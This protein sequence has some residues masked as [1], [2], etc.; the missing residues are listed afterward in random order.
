MRFLR[1]QVLGDGGDVGMLA[2]Q[3]GNRGHSSSLANKSREETLARARASID[4][5]GMDDRKTFDS[6]CLD[7]NA[8]EGSIANRDV[9]SFSGGKEGRVEDG[10]LKMDAKHEVRRSEAF[11]ADTSTYDSADLEDGGN[12]EK[13]HRKDRH[14]PNP[15]S[16]DWNGI[17]HIAAREED[18]DE[19]VR[20]ENSR[21]KSDVRDRGGGRVRARGRA[22]DGAVDGERAS[23]QFTTGENAKLRKE[24]CKS[25]QNQNLEPGKG[26]DGFKD[27]SKKDTDTIHLE[28]DGGADEHHS[29]MVGITDIGF[30]IRKAACAAEEEAR[31]AFAPPE[32]VKAAGDAAAELVR[33][34]SMEALATTNDGEAVLAA[35]NAAVAMVVDAA[36][37]T[38]VSRCAPDAL[39]GDGSVGAEQASEMVG[40]EFMVDTDS[41]EGL[42]ERFCVQCLEKLGEYLEILGPVLQEK[43]VDVCLTL[44][45]RRCRE[46][47]TEKDMTMLSEILKLIC[48]LAAHRKFAALLV[49]RGGV[50]QLLAT[51]RVPQTFSG[52]SL[53]LFAFAS[54]QAVMERV[55]TLPSPI[56]QDVVALA[57]QLLECPQDSA[58]RNAVLFF[59]ASFVF[60]AVLDAFD[61]L[62]GPSKLLTLLRCTVALRSGGISASISGPTNTGSSRGA[63][64]EVLTS[65]GKQI[66][67]HTCVA[68]RQYFRAHLLLLV[69]SLRP[70][71]GRLA[72]RATNTGRAAYKP[73]DISNEAIETIIQQLQ[74]DRKLGPAF[75]RA[76]WL[77]LE[78]FMSSGGH[79]IFLE[80]TQVAPGERYLHEIAQHSLGVLQIVTLM[81]YTRRLVIGSTLSNDRSGMAVILD[82]ASGAGFGDPE[83][84]QPAL[85]V[86]VNLVCPPPSLSSRSGVTPNSSTV[87]QVV[88]AEVKDLPGRGEERPTDIP[89]STG[90]N[91]LQA[92]SGHQSAA[93]PACG[94][95][96]DSRISLGPGSGG[97]GLAAY[98]EQGYRYAREA[99][100]ANNGIKV[101][102]H[103]LYPRTV[104][105]P[106]ALDCIRALACRVLLGLA[107]DDAIAQILTKLQV[108]KLLSEL[109][110]DGIQIGRQASATGD[111]GRWQAELNRVAMDLIAI[112]TNAGRASTIASEAAAPTLRRIERAAIAAATPISYHPR[113]LLQLMHEHLSS[114]GLVDSAATLLKEAQL[115]PLPTSVSAVSVPVFSFSLDSNSQFHQWPS[116][117][118]SGGFPDGAWKQFHKDGENGSMTDVIQS[119]ARKKPSFS[120]MLSGGLKSSSLTPMR[121]TSCTEDNRLQLKDIQE[122]H[123]EAVTSRVNCGDTPDNALKSLPMPRGFPLKRKAADRDFPP[124]SPSKRF[125]LSEPAAIPPYFASPSTRFRNNFISES[126]CPPAGTPL[127]SMHQDIAFKPMDQQDLT[128]ASEKSE[129]LAPCQKDFSAVEHASFT[130]PHLQQHTTPSHVILPTTASES[131]TFQNE[132]ATLDSLVVQYLKHQHR[133][134]PAP[135]TTLP[136]LSLL[137]PHVCPEPS[138][139]LDAPFN[140]AGR[141]AVREIKPPYGGM[142]GNRHNRHFVYSRFRPLR[143]CRDES[144]LVTAATFLC[145]A[146]ILAAGSHAG[147]IRLF[148]SNTGNVLEVHNCH[149]SPVSVLQSSPQALV[150]S[151]EPL[152]GR[153]QLLLSSANYDVRLWDSSALA[154]GPLHNF[155]GCKAA[156]FNHTGSRFGAITLDSSPREV[157]LY[158]VNS[159]KLE[160]KLSDSSLAQA[161][162]SRSHAQ[163]IVHFSPSD[164]LVL[165]SGVLWDH[166]IPQAVHRFDQFTDY[167]GGGFHPSGNEVIINSEVW[168]LR[169]FK[170]LRSV[171]SLDQTVMAFNATGDVIYTTLRR[172][173]D[174]IIAALHPRRAR[175]PL[176]AAFGTL[177][178]VDFSDISITPVDRRVL[179]LA[180]ESTDSLIAVVA[181]DG[182]EEMDSYAKLYEVGRRRPTDDDSDPEEGLETEEEE[183][184]EA[185]NDDDDGDSQADDDDTDIELVSNADGEASDDE[186]D[187][188][189]DDDG[190]YNDSSDDDDDVIGGILQ[191]VSDG[192][193]DQRRDPFSS[194]DEASAG[195]FDEDDFNGILQR[196]F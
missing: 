186:D 63:A 9:D 101:L 177:D 143:T 175:H 19:V 156:R 25:K 86:L 195:E 126:N 66:A 47:S 128:A 138:R 185:E 45:Q 74:R 181:M 178:A 140:T 111:Q 183:D 160:Q 165:W 89:A 125:S 116:G 35:A 24:K 158:D 38:N 100:R 30:A 123:N 120:A 57:L 144:V 50:Q 32:A 56:L 11:E 59:G 55:C 82:A 166:R 133:Q 18:L 65:S 154:N 67:Y 83:V 193:D 179:D 44:L 134:C 190:D 187:G 4:T 127:T 164:V 130:S 145:Q 26:I 102:L 149:S 174:D 92:G 49:D 168:D 97:S 114:C 68:L 41:L 103:L 88:N 109:L 108:A 105:P 106:A 40:A 147:D 48:A 43:G 23:A 161:V 54:L 52:I 153:G 27:S 21:R 22:F 33:V 73:L 78:K 196:L 90:A 71:K 96:G 194:D 69:D 64:G 110:R 75:V 8:E 119:A 72:L 77:A 2:T 188:E 80:L 1:I 132:R 151:E 85:L 171:P 167:G 121:K 122:N 137:H 79:T 163:P 42:R 76:R 139:A 60:R 46:G 146:S 141:L 99:V 104:L 150:T 61:G 192:D 157:M 113:E 10:S 34:A 31:A 81:P 170:L 28:A 20:A 17:S 16:V 184:S 189:H 58:R 5:Q 62:D 159:G 129:L 131:R 12:E 118:V 155:E 142:H 6:I 152:A 191:F 29:F 15:R 162:T 91:T 37:A 70:N 148:D 95:V 117:R 112:V 135:I 169:T 7:K 14:D 36:A 94:L 39:G 98:M 53:C 51:P 172:N 124:L 93:S 3:G 115:T 173:T 87:P 136:P 180:T 13:R 182:N 176:Y 84:I 107:R